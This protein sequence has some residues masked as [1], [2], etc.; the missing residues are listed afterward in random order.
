MY[1]KESKEAPKIDWETAKKINETEFDIN[2]AAAYICDKLCIA[3]YT[4]KNQ[5]ILDVCCKRCPLNKIVDEY[6]KTKN[7][8]EKKDDN[9]EGNT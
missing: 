1:C 2:V 4:V 6:L 7:Q 3:P 8:Q 5:E 9:P